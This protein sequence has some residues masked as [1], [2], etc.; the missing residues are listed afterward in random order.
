MTEQRFPY[1]RCAEKKV[2]V[3]SFLNQFSIK[4]Y[5]PD[6]ALVIDVTS[7]VFRMINT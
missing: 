1:R 6:S 4:A 7:Y 2:S 3:M 5:S